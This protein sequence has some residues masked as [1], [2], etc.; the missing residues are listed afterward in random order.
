ML[1]A[2]TKNR[3]G[4]Q[5]VVISLD[6]QGAKGHLIN[7]QRRLA[8]YRIA[9]VIPGLV[10]NTAMFAEAGKVTLSTVF[11]AKGNEAYVVYILSFDFLY[12]YVEEI[13]NR[14][15]AF[16]SITRS[17]A[18]VRITGTGKNMEKAKE[19]I[20]KI[21]RD[22]PMFKFAFPDMSTIRRL[23]AENS[24]RRKAVASAKKTVS[25]IID[26]D[27]AALAA[28]GDETLEKLLRRIK[29]ARSESD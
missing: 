17:K 14:N 18:W 24:R 2:I 13:E 21:L 8:D 15:K 4:I 19:E 10:D 3:Y 9:S 5:I 25:E 23:D 1:H 6:G 12:D 26:L 28:L 7:L 27:P 16:T 20:D 11:R 29:E 22:L